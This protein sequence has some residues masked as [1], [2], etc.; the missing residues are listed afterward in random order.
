[1]AGRHG[2]PVAE[3]LARTDAHFRKVQN[4]DGSWGYHPSTHKYQDS[5]TCAALMSLAMGHAVYQG[6]PNLPQDPLAPKIEIIQGLR[7]PPENLPLPA[8]PVA[9]KR[10]LDVMGQTLNAGFARRGPNRLLSADS[11]GDLYFLW[12]LER[13]AMIYN[14]DT[15]GNKKWYPWAAR[16]L[17][18]SQKPDGSWHDVFA[19]PIDTSFALLILKRSNRAGDLT[20]MIRKAV[21]EQTLPLL[22]GLLPK[23]P[24]ANGKDAGPE[25]PRKVEKVE[26]RPRIEP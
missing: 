8:R 18:D 10:G 20:T 11:L 16:L 24:Q 26:P 19:G 17:V 6:Y 5:M 3:S 7:R 2:V 4:L 12:S 15:V 23:V 21:D 14:I 22:P 1:V 13:M 25:R 9:I